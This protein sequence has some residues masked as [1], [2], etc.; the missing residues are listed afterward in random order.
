MKL[1]I[2][3]PSSSYIGNCKDSIEML[4][5]DYSSDTEARLDANIKTTVAV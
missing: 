4:H 5:E 2:K 3:L 1:E